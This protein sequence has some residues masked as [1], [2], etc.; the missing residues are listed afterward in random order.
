MYENSAG[1]KMFGVLVVTIWYLAAFLPAQADWM[2]KQKLLASDGAIDDYFGMSV[3][4]TDDGFYAIVGVP[5]DD[6]NGNSS[7]SAYIFKWNGTSWIEHQN[8]LASDG[9]ASDY[10]GHSVS[11]SGDY[12]VVG[13]F[14]DDDNGSN[15]GSAYVFKRALK[16]VPPNFVWVFEEQVK[17]LPADGDADD[18]FGFTVFISG[19]YVIVGAPSDDDKGS[20]SGSAYI[21][22]RYDLDWLQQAKLIASDGSADDNFGHSVSISGDYAIVGVP[23]DDDNGSGSGSAYIFKRDGVNWLQQPKLLASDGAADDQFGMSVSISGDYAVVG[24]PNDDDKGSDSGSAY[25]FKRDAAS[26]LQQPKRA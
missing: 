14:Y 2:E 11:I 16:Y 6:D 7:G 18:H 17:L 3:S 12:A 5:Y 25:I 19:D 10:F 20:E 4:I 15:S 9:V 1:K 8:L 13:A 23:Y 21:F 24:A 22:K 26:W